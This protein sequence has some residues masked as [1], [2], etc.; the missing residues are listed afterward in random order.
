[1]NLNDPRLELILRSQMGALSHEEHAQLD[2]LL[3]EDSPF[4]DFY[5]RY[6]NLDLAVADLARSSPV[7]VALPVRWFSA[8]R[9]W[10]F[11]AASEHPLPSGIPAT[12][13]GRQPLWRI[14]LA[15]IAVAAIAFVLPVPKVVVDPCERLCQNASAEVFHWTMQFTGIPMTR[16]GL[17]FQL[18]GLTLEFVQACSGFRST[19]VLLS[20]G[21]LITPRVLKRTLNRSLFMLAILPLEIIQKGLWV[22]ALTTLVIRVDPTLIDTWFHRQNQA[23]SFVMSLISLAALLWWLYRVERRAKVNA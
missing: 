1:M 14:A 13:L 20:I 9:R 5:V 3:R 7:P 6:V 10:L 2:R 12:G 16:D 17:T 19:F 21:A 23:I 15:V 22:S 4:R 11:G 8:L 18:P